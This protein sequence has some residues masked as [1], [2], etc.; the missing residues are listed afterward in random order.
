MNGRLI[1]RR[2]G[3]TVIEVTVQ[4]VVD[5]AFHGHDR[6]WADFIQ[7]VGYAIED[8]PGLSLVDDEVVTQ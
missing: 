8:K 4:V 5:H 7:T 1:E 2:P 3:E 6:H